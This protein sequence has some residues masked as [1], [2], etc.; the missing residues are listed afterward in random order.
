MN[1]KQKIDL[2][3]I[4]LTS[5]PVFLITLT[6][7]AKLFSFPGFSDLLSFVFSLAFSY[8]FG[9]FNLIYF[10]SSFLAKKLAQD[11]KGKKYL[12]YIFVLGILNLGAVAIGLLFLS[13]IFKGMG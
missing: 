4:I 13:I 9:L 7:I 2:A 3:I 6:I 12:R 11:E 8:I 1:K 10:L 5:I